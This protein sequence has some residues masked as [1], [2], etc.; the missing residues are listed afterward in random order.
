MI[1]H[2]P[3]PRVQRPDRYSSA[4]AIHGVRLEFPPLADRFDVVIGEPAPRG[5]G[6][7]FRDFRARWWPGE[8]I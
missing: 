5:D 8:A 3:Q 4:S 1:A 6:N 7:M 2:Q